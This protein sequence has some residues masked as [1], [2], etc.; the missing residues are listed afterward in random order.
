[1]EI[2][3]TVGVPNPRFIEPVTL[4]GAHATVEPLAREH[5]GAIREAAADG[6]LWKLWY[7]SVPA[8]TKTSAWLDIALDMRERLAPPPAPSVIGAG[9]A[10]KPSGKATAK[11]VRDAEAAGPSGT[12]RDGGTRNADG[13]STVKRARPARRKTSAG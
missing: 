2:A 1:M 8:P 7:T 6:E 13:G 12:G 4:T 3:A 9:R 11:R 10:A 5:E